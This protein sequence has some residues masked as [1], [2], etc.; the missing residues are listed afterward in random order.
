MIYW[1]LERKMRKAWQERCLVTNRPRCDTNAAVAVP[2]APLDD[3]LRDLRAVRA[4]LVKPV[5]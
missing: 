2:Y 1:G 5:A 4:T 3:V